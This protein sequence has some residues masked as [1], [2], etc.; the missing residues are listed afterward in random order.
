MRLSLNL[1]GLGCNMPNARDVSALLTQLHDRKILNLDASLRT[2]LQPENLDNLD[3]GSKVGA[4]VIAWDG[5]GLVIKGNI[6][7]VSEV[8]QLGQGIREQIG[9]R[10]PFDR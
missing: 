10:G 1:T 8:A 9:P 3:P 6:A 4:A 7:S 5:Y 2:V